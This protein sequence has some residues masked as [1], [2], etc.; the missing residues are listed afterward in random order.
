M[1]NPLFPNLLLSTVVILSVRLQLLLLDRNLGVQLILSF[2]FDRENGLRELVGC[3]VTTVAMTISFAIGAG[4]G[5]VIG[6]VAISIV[7]GS[8][9]RGVGAQE[10]GSVGA[11]LLRGRGFGILRVVGFS[12]GW[13]GSFG[14]LIC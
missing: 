9:F 11:Q 1:I 8:W 12:G 10:L 4:I 7:I 2:T 13:L 6:D 14:S 3:S 5:F